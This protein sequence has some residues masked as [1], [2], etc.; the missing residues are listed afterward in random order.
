MFARVKRLSPR[1]PA[2][3]LGMEGLAQHML[4]RHED[5]IVTLNE[6][7][8]RLPRG[9]FARPRLIAV[10]ADLDRL[11]EARAA[12]AELLKLNPEFSVKN[13]VKAQPFKA[14]ERKEW[15]RDLLLKAGLPE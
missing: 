4:G 9:P 13:Y 11:E 10:Y 3:I 14:P 5:A 8:R 12:A 1:Y 6:D 7:I 15:M 2:W